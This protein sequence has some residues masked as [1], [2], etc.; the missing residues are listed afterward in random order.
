M[1]DELENPMAVG[2]YYDVCS[3]CG[4]LLASGSWYHTYG[5]GRKRRCLCADCEEGEEENDVG[6]ET[7]TGEQG[8]P[9]PAGDQ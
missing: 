1:R 4:A 5:I 6:D 9:G 7:G 8:D 3:R 2:D